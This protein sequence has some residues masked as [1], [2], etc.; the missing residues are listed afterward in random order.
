MLV[1]IL[2]RAMGVGLATVG[3]LGLTWWLIAVAAG[4]E[5]YARFMACATGWFGKTVAIGLTFAF[6]FH[7]FSG[8]RHFV[9]D[10]GAGFELKT[11][12]L[13]S[14]MVIGG[15]VTATLVMWLFILLGR[16]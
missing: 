4:P 13:W 1:S 16:A 9:L 2:N 8:I 15:A 12:R 7:L 11:N 3:A 6:F 5:A 14:L 10:T